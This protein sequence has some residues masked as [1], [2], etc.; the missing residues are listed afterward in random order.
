MEDT[1]SKNGRAISK[2]VAAVSRGKEELSLLTRRNLC[3]Q[4]AHHVP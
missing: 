1:G 4:G 2:R 3:N